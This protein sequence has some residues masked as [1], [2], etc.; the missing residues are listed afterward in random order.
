MSQKSFNQLAGTIFLIVA[1]VHFFR[2]ING[3]EVNIHTFAVPM[4]LSWVGVIL[5]GY[6]AYQGL[7]KK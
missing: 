3:W 2:V 1:V 6:L 7:R 4:W 5:I